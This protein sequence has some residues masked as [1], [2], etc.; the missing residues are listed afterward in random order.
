[1]KLNDLSI[2]NANSTEEIR[3][4]LVANK[5]VLTVQKVESLIKQAKNVSY[6]QGF[7]D[8]Q[9]MYELDENRLENLA[10]G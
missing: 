6:A 7:S 4:R 8:A 9:K 5:T 3:Q 2:I 1:M 10:K